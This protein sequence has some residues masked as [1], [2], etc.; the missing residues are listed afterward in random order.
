M[1]NGN[2]TRRRELPPLD[3]LRGFEAAA[4]L[5]SFTLAADELALTQSAVSRQI[6]SLEEDLGVQLFL[7]AHRSLRLTEEGHL[8]YHTVAESL[9]Q[10]RDVTA[11][12][13]RES[14]RVTVT[15]TFGFASIWLIPRL[16]RF[17]SAHPDIDVHISASNEIVDL[18]KSRIHVAVRYS[19]PGLAPGGAIKLFDDEVIRICAASLADSG[20]RPL[21]VPADLAGHVLLHLEGVDT[22][23]PSLSW[24]AWLEALNLG[25][26]K[27]AGELW[28]S[29]YDQMIQ[30]ALDGQGVALGSEPL[31]RQALQNGRLIIPFARRMATPRAYYVVVSPAGARRRE[32]DSFVTWLSAEARAASEATA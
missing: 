4:R 10:L 5:R 12:L 13:R 11:A 22:R 28:F 30:A 32:V 16:A 25:D 31:V 26:L 2:V 29:H 8:L 18:D 7:R 6:Q 27:P 17:R 3:L 14:G 23:T 21:Q 9:R 19:T 24:R 15:T 20:N 1:S